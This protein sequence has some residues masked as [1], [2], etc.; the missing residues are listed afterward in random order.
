MNFMTK[1]RSSPGLALRGTLLLMVCCAL[2][3][4]SA[5]KECRDGFY[6]SP[7]GVC[8]LLCPAGTFKVVDCIA[9]GRKAL[10]D[11]CSKGTY[12]DRDNQEEKCLWCSSC[13][14]GEEVDVDCSVAQDTVCRCTEGLKR[15]GH[16][17]NCLPE[18]PHTDITQ[19]TTVAAIVLS[20]VLAVLLIAV[21]IFLLCSKTKLKTLILKFSSN[22][23]G[24]TLGANNNEMERL[25][26]VVTE[27]KTPVNATKQP[28]YSPLQ[29]RHESETLRLIQKDRKHLKTWIGVDPAHLLK[30]LNDSLMIPR[31]LY[32][33]AKSKSGEETAEVILNHFI[34]LGEKGCER[35][36]NALYSVRTHYVQLWMWLQK[37]GEA[38]W[39]V[40]QKKADLKIWIG[41]KPQ[42][43]L[44]QLMSR[45]RI[46]N[47]LFSEARK[48]KNGREC[49]E[50]IIDYF[51]NK[52]NDDCLKLL[53]A[54]HAVQ[55]RYPKV[56][57]WLSSLEFFNNLSNT[58]PLHLNCYTDRVLQD[59]IRFNRK[60]LVQAFASNIDPLFTQL[61]SRRLFTRNNIRTLNEMEAKKAS[62]HV[63]E[64]V[65]SK[66]QYR[67]KAFWELLWELKHSYPALEDI[68]CSF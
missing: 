47:D 36:W 63:L 53:F 16:S 64:L 22:R 42:H 20:C 8:C 3:E 23:S 33:K 39:S 45:G 13:G 51:I 54:L 68:F 66:D 62:A 35:L 24:S 49:A 59:K 50:R 26:Q 5:A 61:H 44:V 9:D 7:E 60:R 21:A 34:Q 37:H 58:C 30:H 31:D 17:G 6:K 67:A 43:L 38:V 27:G 40:R 48:I 11:L 15:N 25:N 19:H 52:G 32:R 14:S 2:Q 1:R 55:D 18:E 46:S 57:L 12:M 65:L 28:S 56:K 29:V 41:E 10:C 4:P